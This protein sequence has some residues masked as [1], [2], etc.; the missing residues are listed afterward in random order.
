MAYIF[1]INEHWTG[2]PFYYISK[3]FG[4]K[5]ALSDFALNNSIDDEYE[6]LQMYQVS[7][8]PVMEG[9]DILDIVLPIY[10]AK[11]KEEQEKYRLELNKADAVRELERFN[12]LKNKLYPNTHLCSN[13]FNDA[14]VCLPT[15]V[16]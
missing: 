13:Y 9:L 8:N 2:D 14:H 12:E 6:W 11:L 16:K 3:C 10:K 7:D 4:I 15:G 1:V 5:D